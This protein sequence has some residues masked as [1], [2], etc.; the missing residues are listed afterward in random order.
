MQEVNREFLSALILAGGQSSRMGRDKA[1]IEIDGVPLIRRVYEAAQFCT[2]EIYVL[3]PW[4]DRYYPVLPQTCRF[5]QEQAD[6]KTP[7]GPLVGFSQGLAQVQTEWVLLL[8]CDLP[9]LQP[10]ILQSW[11]T[12]LSNTDNATIALLPQ[13]PKGWDPLCG[14]YRRFCLDSL[15]T[16]IQK[17][18]RSFQGWLTQVP[19]QALPLSDRTMLL[20]CNTPTDLETLS[21]PS[22]NP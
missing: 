8:A 22:P 4:S 17:G 10:A 1:L 2:S 5:L 15:R 7:Q 3:A 9:Q 11:T 20:N 6:P 13:H 14:F 19:V 21:Y 16:F 18:G 12:R